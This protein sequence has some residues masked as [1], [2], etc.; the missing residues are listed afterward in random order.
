MS[1][2]SHDIDAT[3][4]NTH[5]LLLQGIADKGCERI[6]EVLGCDKSTVSRTQSEHLPK[7]CK[8]LAF[9]GYKIVP[10]DAQVLN[11][12]QLH[13]VDLM[14]ASTKQ[15]INQCGNITD[16]LKTDAQP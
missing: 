8:L 6:G 3:A 5:A 14:F 11:D 2:S 7:L 9:L 10:I 16:F 12:D 1:E 13:L 4:R 15:R